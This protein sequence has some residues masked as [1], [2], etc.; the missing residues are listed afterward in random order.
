[1]RLI[2]RQVCGQVYEAEL[3]AH[4]CGRFMDRIMRLNYAPNYAAGLWTEL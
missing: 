2:M 3:R 1:M 4:L